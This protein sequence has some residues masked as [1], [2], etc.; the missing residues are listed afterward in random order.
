MKNLIHKYCAL[1]QAEGI[2]PG[3]RLSVYAY[4]LELLLSGLLNTGIVLILSVFLGQGVLALFFLAGFIPMR[5]FAGGYHADTHLNCSTIFS[6]IYL[7]S[8]V[9]RNH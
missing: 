8:I 3:E 7:L 4:G 9:L 6:G 5:I 2:I 1:L